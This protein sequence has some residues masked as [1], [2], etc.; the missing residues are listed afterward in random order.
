VVAQSTYSAANQAYLRPRTR[1]T[2]YV[3]GRS[4]FA[5][6]I[7]ENCERQ[8]IGA[9]VAFRKADKLLLG[10]R[11]PLPLERDLIGTATSCRANSP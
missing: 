10:L 11:G 5:P 3:I 9:N 4:N 6:S 2:Q 7:D 1:A 8:N